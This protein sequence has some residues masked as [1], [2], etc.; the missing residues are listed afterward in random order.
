MSATTQISIGQVKRDISELVNRVAYAGERIVLTSRGKPKAVLVSLEDLAQLQR[1]QSNP[2]QAW[3]AWLAESAQL[4][5]QIL[6]R[7]G[8]QDVD[9]D[10]AWGAARAEL[11]QHGDAETAPIQ[12][13]IQ[14]DAVKNDAVKNDAS[15][16]GKRKHGHAARRS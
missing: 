9:A 2:P 11:E 4:N 15:R 12:A 14:N 3:Q 13:P 8:G 5:E 10:A 16:N 6:A 7:R 1:P